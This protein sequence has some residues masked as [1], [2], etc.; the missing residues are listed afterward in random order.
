MINRKRATQLKGEL[1]DAE[2]ETKWNGFAWGVFAWVF[3]RISSDIQ[4]GTVN[5]TSSANRIARKLRKIRI[6]NLPQCRVVT[7]TDRF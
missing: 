3:L 1:K 6:V 5:L 4:N 2:L 7:G